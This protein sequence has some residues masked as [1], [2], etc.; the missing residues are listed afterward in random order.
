MADTKYETIGLADF[1]DVTSSGPIATPSLNLVNMKNATWTNT[2]EC[3]ILAHF[4]YSLHIEEVLLGEKARFQVTKNTL[5]VR[6]EDSIRDSIER[7]LC[8][9]VGKFWRQIFLHRRPCNRPV[10]S[11]GNG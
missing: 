1:I 9:A 7:A 11:T 8:G 4:L 6:A 3:M 2:P 10:S 5:A